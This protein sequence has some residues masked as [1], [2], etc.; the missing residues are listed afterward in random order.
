VPVAAWRFF[1]SGFFGKNL[2]VRAHVFKI[3]HKIHH[4]LALVIDLKVLASEMPVGIRIR[5]PGNVFDKTFKIHVM[6]YA[7]ALHGI[8]LSIPAGAHHLVQITGIKPGHGVSH[9]GEQK[10]APPETAGLSDTHGLFYAVFHLPFFRHR[11]FSAGPVR[12]DV[13]CLA[14]AEKVAKRGGGHLV[15]GNVAHPEI[16][17]D[18]DPAAVA[19]VL[20]LVCLVAYIFENH[21]VMPFRRIEEEIDVV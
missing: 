13:L 16:F 8:L 3:A 15:N 17:D 11:Q 19:Q 7:V 18:Q 14:A 21:H 5:D 2:P 4:A 1:K 10:I 9:K 20:P 6:A 12:Q